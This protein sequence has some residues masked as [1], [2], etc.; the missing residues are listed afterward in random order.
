MELWDVYTI[1]GVLTGRKIE[2]AAA[3]PEGAYHLCAELWLLDCAGRILIQRRSDTRRLLPGVWTMTT[4]CVKAGEASLD[5]IV[6]EAR[7][8]L[9]LTLQKDCVS[10]ICRVVHGSML[11]DIWAARAK[12]PALTLQAEEVS[13]TRWVTPGELRD[14]MASGGIFTYPEMERVLQAVLERFVCAV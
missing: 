11:W 2:R 3:L 12:A 8:E 4:G 13:Q 14:L 7:E 10:Y 5:G 1:D 9:G 6:R